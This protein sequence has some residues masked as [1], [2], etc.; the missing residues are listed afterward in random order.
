VR[1]HDVLALFNPEYYPQTY[2]A[3]SNAIMINDVAG[4]QGISRNDAE[5]WANELR[6]PG[7]EGRYFLSV[8]RAPRG[9]SSAGTAF[10]RVHAVTR[11]TPHRSGSVLPCRPTDPGPGR[12]HRSELS[13]YVIRL[14]LFCVLWLKHTLT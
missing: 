1:H 11:H 6:R 3:S 9:G 14:M 5:A 8:N 4:R 7:D 13:L 12:G 2:R 10:G